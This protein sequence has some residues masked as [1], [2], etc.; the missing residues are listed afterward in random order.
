MGCWADRAYSGSL[1]LL[2]RPEVSGFGPH[3]ALASESPMFSIQ[4]RRVR[5]HLHTMKANAP[6][7]TLMQVQV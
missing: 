4:H 7:R 1:K 6:K 2:P 3:E 5:K